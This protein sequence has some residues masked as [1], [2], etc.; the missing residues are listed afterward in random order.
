MALEDEIKALT[1]AVKELT[2]V[3]KTSTSV[4]TEALAVAKTVTETTKAST[5]TADKTTKAADK[6][7]PETKTAQAS[8]AT[9]IYAGLKEIVAD[10]LAVDR[11]EERTARQEKVVALLN[12]EK[13][14]KPGLAADAKPDLANIAPDAIELFKKQ[15]SLLKDKGDLTTPAKPEEDDLL[16]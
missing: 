15:M 7:A 12:H 6:K 9:D 13:I 16:S 10:Y 8:D 14:K 5:E 2:E 11:K 1:A 3:T 4:R